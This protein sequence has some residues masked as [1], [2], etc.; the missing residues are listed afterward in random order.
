MLE[1]SG[2]AVITDDTIFSR[3]ASVSKRRRYITKG[4]GSAFSSA[5]DIRTGEHVVHV[6]YGIGRY[7]GLLNM[8]AGA[9]KKDFLCL[10]Y[11]GGDKLYMPVEDVSLV[12]KYVGFET[13]PE[14]SRLGTSGWERAKERAKEDV[15]RTAE[16]LLRF[17]AERE[18]ASSYRFGE[19]TPWQKEF[20]EEFLYDLTPDQ[21][22]TVQEIKKDMGSGR[23]VDR[24]INSSRR[25]SPTTRR[26]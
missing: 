11:A 14:L 19:D 10:E 12:H 4:A 17:Y 9:F 13:V 16:E 25:S 2:I 3:Y 5:E 18:S 21:E 22:R 8:E 1:P 26:R 24:L 7:A 23:P 6:N 15:R 20:E